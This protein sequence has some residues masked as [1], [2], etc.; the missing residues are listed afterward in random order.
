M[1]VRNKYGVGRRRDPATLYLEEE[2]RWELR[3]WKGGGSYQGARELI[4]GAL[5]WPGS[6]PSFSWLPAAASST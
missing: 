1:T 2:R 5:I 6:L 3:R 4:E